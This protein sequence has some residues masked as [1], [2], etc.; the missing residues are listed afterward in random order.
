MKPERKDIDGYANMRSSNGNM[1]EKALAGQ[2][3]QNYK[4][5]T[6][7]SQ[8]TGMDK[9]IE[10]LMKMHELQIRRLKAIRTFSQWVTNI[11]QW[12]QPDIE[13]MERYN[14]AVERLYNLYRTT[15]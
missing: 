4:V 3:G 15:I 8:L 13:R 2:T 7:P 11:S 6:K 10:P 9:A 5:T 12:E 14:K 1:L